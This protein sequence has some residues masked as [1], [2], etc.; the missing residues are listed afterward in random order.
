M[1]VCWCA[2]ER[3]P[4]EEQGGQEEQEQEELS[5]AARDQSGAAAERDARRRSTG[6]R[7]RSRSHNTSRVS[8]EPQRAAQRPLAVLFP[9]AARTSMRVASAL[10]LS[11]EMDLRDG[12][13]IILEPHE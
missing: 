1:F 13:S 5:A 2:A 8:C 3:R 11:R 10:L 12:E 6:R 7:S 9:A 4:Q